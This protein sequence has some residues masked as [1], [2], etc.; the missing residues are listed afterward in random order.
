MKEKGITLIAL[1]VTI[2]VLIILAGITIATLTGDDGIINNANNAKEETEIANEKEIVD[3]ATINAMGNNK[4]GNIVKD[5]LQ[6]E[7]DRI[8]KVGDTEVE[9]NGEEFEVFFVKTNRYY[10]VDIDGDIV[11][12]G[13][14]VIDKS[15]GDITKDENGNDIEEGK[16]YEIWCIEDLVAF[17]N[18]VNGNGIILENGK[19]IE[20]DTPTNFSN[21]TV[22][23]K[24]NLNFKSKHSYAN[25]ERTDFGDING[26]EN[27]GN[28]LMNEMTTGTG[29]KPIGTENDYFRGAF[30][31][32]GKE[33]NNI[34]IDTSNN[35][36]LFGRVFYATVENIKISGL[37]TSKE[38]HAGGIIA[39]GPATIKNCNNEATIN[40]KGYAG[41]IVGAGGWQSISLE[42]SS[43][44]GD[45]YSEKDTVA[46]I[47]GS[48]AG[49][50]NNCYN[51]GNV[52]SL[53]GYSSG[54]LGQSAGKVEI[55][56]CFNEGNINSKANA[57]G[58]IT[59]YTYAEAT[60]NNCYNTGNIITEGSIITS[61][62]SNGIGGTYANNCYNI[63]NL[64]SIRKCYA[65]GANTMTN[66]YYNSTL[67]GKI[68]DENN[69][70]DISKLDKNEFVNLLNSYTNEETQ[71][72]SDW[73]K[74][75]IGEN[76]YPTFE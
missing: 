34:Y 55:T 28:T 29:F 41:G 68:E 18:M 62:N 12:E 24:T 9:D 64:K 69:I 60:V 3:R 38:H 14:I 47:A 40:A 42:N 43:N 58:G 25:S 51:L 45:I 56:N 11:E 35:A 52:E 66:C 36:G 33:V 50:I 48:F 15:P 23:L 46:G 70:E 53:R 13:E 16:P 75:E 67:V 39:E 4:R 6:D 76:G 44:T 57:S 10:I 31:G 71:Y 73:R 49:K 61:A 2:I 74:W 27:D 20:I 8:T 32:N 7:L 72:P 54:I 22:E 37:I 30:E 5:E 17:S 59:A 63:G 65:I 1:I 26:N 19:A 21:K